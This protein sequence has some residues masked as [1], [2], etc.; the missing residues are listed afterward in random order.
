MPAIHGTIIRHK[1]DNPV[2][3]PVDKSIN[4]RETAVFK[5]RIFTAFIIKEFI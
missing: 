3:I 2:P 1:E 5:K 4:R